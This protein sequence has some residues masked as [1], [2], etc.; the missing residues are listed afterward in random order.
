MSKHRRPSPDCPNSSQDN[1]NELNEAEFKD[2]ERTI[3][4]ILTISVIIV[5]LLTRHL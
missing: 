3:L 4:L 2:M 1:D 5:C